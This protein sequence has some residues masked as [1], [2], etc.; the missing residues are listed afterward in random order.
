MTRPYQ[1]TTING[2]K[3]ILYPLSNLPSIKLQLLVKAGSWHEAGESWGALHLLEHLV[4]KGTK[5]FINRNKIELYKETHGLTSNAY[6]GGGI[7][8]FWVKG[9]YYS[10]TQAI[11]LLN[12]IVFRPT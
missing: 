2:I 1:I 7:T 11:T 6:T 10:I 3:T 12:Q 9:P 8:G 4:H 5:K